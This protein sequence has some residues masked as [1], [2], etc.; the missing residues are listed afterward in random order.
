[1]NAAFRGQC[2][3]A[4][5]QTGR[6]GFEVAVPNPKLKLLDRLREA[7]RLRHYSI[8]TE[9]ALAGR[10]KAWNSPANKGDFAIHTG[11]TPG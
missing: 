4:P 9:R 7:L 11:Y 6:V 10:G 8:Q 2:S 1:M 5:L 3:D